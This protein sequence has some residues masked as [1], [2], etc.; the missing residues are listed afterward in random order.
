M[1]TGLRAWARRAG[2]AA[3]IVAAG[4]AWA[5]GGPARAQGAAS[6]AG[7]VQVP[8][9]E[10]PAARSLRIE[11]LD[12][13]RSELVLDLSGPTP[14]RAF[15]LADPPRMALDF[16][17]VD[18]SQTKARVDPDGLA[19]AARFGLFAP[20][21]SRLV[22]DLARPVRIRHGALSDTRAGARLRLLLEETD[23][24]SFA[25]LA[26]W[27]DDA[28]PAA[29]PPPPQTD[30]PPVV[31][32]DPGHGGVDPGA[33]RGETMEKDLVL[34]FAQD[35]FA[36]LE[37]SGRWRPVMTRTGDVFVSLR[38]RVAFAEAA[39]AAAFLSI[40]VNALESGEATGASIHTLSREASSEEAAALAA[41]ENRADLLAGV[42]LEGEG[43]DV[44]RALID[45]SR[46]R[47][48]KRSRGLGEALVDA[49][50]GRA[51][52]LEG[53]AHSHAGFR[54]LKSPTVPSA[55]VELGFM[56]TEG[57]LEKIRDPAWRARVAA[58]M[59]EA[60]ADW[61]GR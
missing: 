35:L 5:P 48:D 61:A 23:A 6:P 41:F 17:P 20:G 50:R 14:W 10:A 58:G 60:L 9:A 42:S 57:D 11:R 47:T 31:V 39:G 40:H 8:A 52:L 13:R 29:P 51:A 46:R 22:V 43:D 16:G 26:G 59:V 4:L 1:E 33:I 45:L 24:E 19:S 55:L 2:A 44:A 56:S 18:W 7:G 28:R 32:I 12:R 38:D 25:A 3:L 37:A 34:A 15:F 30:G 53:R 21:R 27:P 49:L 36:A 54:V